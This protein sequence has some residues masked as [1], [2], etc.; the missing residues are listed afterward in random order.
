MAIK[1]SQFITQTSASSLSHIVGYNGADN[2]QIT[3]ANFFTSFAVGNTGQVSYFD[4]ASSLEGSNEFVWDSNNNRLGIGTSS[5]AV[6]L[7]VAGT[8]AP[9]IRV[10]DLDGTNQFINIGHNNGNTTYVSRN[11]TSFGTHVFYGANGSATTERMRVTSSGYVGI[12]TDSPVSKLDVIG[13]VTAQGTLVATGI[14]QLGSGGSNVYLTS[15]SAGNVGIGTSSPT[16]KLDVEADSSSGVVSVKNAANGRDT[17]RSENAAGTRTLNF[18]NDGSGHGLLL[19]RSSSGSV[20]NYIAGN[21]DSYFNGGNVGIGTSS[22]SSKLMIETGSDEGIRIYRSSANANFGAIEFRNSNDTATNSRIGFNSNELRLEATSTQRFVTDGSDALVI[23][24]SQNAT[25]AGDVIIDNSS[26]DPFLKLMTAAQQYVLRIDQSDAEKFQIRNTTSSVTAL[27]IDRSSNATFAGD[28]NVLG[29]D[30]NFSTNGFADINNT[31]TGA[32]RLRPSGTATALTI[33][34]SDATFT[35]NIITSSTSGN[36]GIKIITATDAEGFLVFGDADD[37]SMGGIA[38]NN[39][40]NSLSIDCNNA[41]RISINSA[42]NVGIGTTSPA[43]KLQVDSGSDFSV[44]LSKR[45]STSSALKF[46][47]SDPSITTNTW[48]IEHD[49]S[50]NLKIFGYST[51]NLL[52]STNSVERMRVTS[53]GNVLFGTTGIPN[54]TSVY[55]SGFIPGSNDR[56]FLN[57]ATSSTSTKEHL[58][59][60]NPNGKVG[61]IKTLNSATQFNTSSDYR[62]KKDLKD[63]DGLDKV[64]KIPVYDFKWKVDDSSSYGVMAH[65]LQDILPDAVSGEKDG[66]EMQGVDYSKIV[67][68]LIKSIQELKAEVEDLKS[69]I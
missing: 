20:T 2:I 28:I 4:S 17:F 54:G 67:P 57:L 64:S 34:S 25:F 56:M 21:G 55:G 32:I 33:S 19:I 14:S 35:G 52:I 24:T 11:N 31:G 42:G 50:E 5:P 30:V 46:T 12:G 16:F 41:E 10:Q 63:F 59:F 15:S 62:L 22:P 36:K 13:G 47:L 26:G 53:S 7:H 66:E 44:A 51:D 39:N 18:G 43:T 8:G 3:P 29:E 9:D 1:F 61:T 60:F 40:T 45:G 58:Q 37:N 6:Q 68:L 23:D 27:S 48:K 38:Y 49:S 65:E 69:K